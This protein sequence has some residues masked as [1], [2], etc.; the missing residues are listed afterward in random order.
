MFSVLQKW[1][2]VATVE[3]LLPKAFCNGQIGRASLGRA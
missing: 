2:N 1:Y 3:Q